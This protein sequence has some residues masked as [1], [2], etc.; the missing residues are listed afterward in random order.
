MERSIESFVRRIREVII[1]RSLGSFDCT[2]IDLTIGT[3]A[4][5]C[6]FQYFLGRDQST[7]LA[8]RPRT[9][10]RG[11]NKLLHIVLN[12]IRHVS[13]GSTERMPSGRFV[14]GPSALKTA[15][16]YIIILFPV[17]YTAEE[18]KNTLRQRRSFDIENYL[19][20]LR[21]KQGIIGFLTLL[22]TVNHCHRSALTDRIHIER[23]MLQ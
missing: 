6:Y 4:V 15:V 8:I 20:M 7:L 14:I 22:Q 3:V 11:G 12:E 1:L 16:H 23:S 19:S 21:R 5:R 13:G 10:L 9:H 2:G 17:S 18:N